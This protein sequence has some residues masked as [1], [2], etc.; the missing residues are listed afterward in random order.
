M[1]QLTFNILFSASSIFL[2]AISFSIIFSTTKFFH[3]AHAAVIAIAPYV[4][5]KLSSLFNFPLVFC[6]I[7]TILFTAFFGWLIDRVFYVPMRKHGASS[8]ILL[9]ASLGLYILIQNTISLVFG[10]DTKMF[11]NSFDSI[12]LSFF[13]AKITFVQFMTI[14]SA[15][16][17]F[18]AKY[19]LIDKTKIG[20]AL[21]AV[22]DNTTLSI[23]SGVNNKQVIGISFFL[24]SFIAGI[25][26]LLH[27]FDVG[28]SPTMG[29]PMLL[30]GVV[31]VILAGKGKVINLSLIH[32]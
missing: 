26:G 27:A 3:F 23:I 20:L 29:L 16:I 30:L 10:D 31:A 18:F 25:A 11:K 21:K 9:L 22:A 8:L 32:I 19:Y 7:L 5:I 1:S 4:L 17:I 6:I 15:V 24:G 28:V 14:T 12:S 13:G 2:V